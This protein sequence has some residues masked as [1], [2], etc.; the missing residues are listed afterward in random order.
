M[1]SRDKFLSELE[2]ACQQLSERIGRPIKAIDVLNLSINESSQS[3]PGNPSLLY[4]YEGYMARCVLQRVQ[5]EMDYI[6]WQF[7]ALQKQY[8]FMVIQL[9]KK[10]TSDEQWFTRLRSAQLAVDLRRCLDQCM[11]MS[12]QLGIRRQ[13]V[14]NL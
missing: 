1:K 14:D 6:K 12:I 3:N 7:V 2:L 11:E 4:R 9:E 8:A 5:E 10:C 13:G